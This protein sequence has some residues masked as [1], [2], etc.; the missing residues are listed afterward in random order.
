MFQLKNIY[1]F[2]NVKYVYILHT[3]L[4]KKHL[5]QIGVDNKKMNLY[6][7]NHALATCCFGFTKIVKHAVCAH[8]NMR[9]AGKKRGCIECNKIFARDP[10]P[11][12][13]EWRVTTNLFIPFKKIH[14][15]LKNDHYNQGLVKNVPSAA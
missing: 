5:Q 2:R 13:L 3:V 6:K 12:I 1:N 14:G 11:I 9:S 7:I 10:G 8:C 4:S 15:S